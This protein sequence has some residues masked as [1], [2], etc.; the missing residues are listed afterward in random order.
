LRKSSL[1]FLFINLIFIANCWSQTLYLT[2]EGATKDETRIIDSLSYINRFKDIESFNLEKKIFEK[3]LYTL[4]YIENNE[5]SNIKINDSTY[6]TTYALNTL[7]KSINV[8][9]DQELISKNLLASVSDNIHADYFSI[10]FARVEEK[11]N[12]IN[13]QLA[14]QGTPF[15]TL[16]LKNIQKKNSNSLNANLFISKDLKRAINKIVINGYEKFSKSF[17]KR[18]L[19]IR[20][21]E[22]FDLEN[23]KQK[24]QALNELSF[25][26]QVKS[27]EVLFTKDSTTLYM[28]LEKKPSNTFDGFLGFGTN[29]N[30]NKIAFDG[31]LNLNLINN[32][33]YGE[34]LRLL[35]KSDENEQKTFEGTLELPYIF[36]SPM[37]TELQLNIF[38]KDSSFTTIRQ[39]AKLFYQINPKSKVLVGVN[40]TQSNNLLDNMSTLLIDD[41]NTTFYNLGYSYA[42]RERYSALFPV[43]FKF[44]LEVG[45]GKRTFEN[46]DLKQTNMTYD[47]FKIFNLNDKNSL[48]IRSNGA[49]LF[50]DNYF[51]NELYRFGGINSIRGFE[52]NSLFAS[53][54]ALINTE[55][56][57]KL[58]N[59]IYIHSIIDAAYYEND[60]ANLK[61]KLF[62]FGFGFGLLT[63]SGLLKF[64]YA[65]G[66]NENKKFKFSDSKIHISL[67][68]S[69]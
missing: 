24:T 30:T 44:F 27:P 41:Y 49:F 15:K 63:N 17:L 12:Y 5:I 55:Y 65:N 7:Y 46:S 6:L 51:F 38:K 18:Y 14:N 2:I 43:N 40:A 13:R 64:N 53:G 54:F 39:L 67:T 20:L 56:R 60:I 19:K 21:H 61:E 8:Y 32:L 28:Y 66:K 59:S 33:N 62:G 9:Y 1:L 35:Y 3:K 69:F 22:T 52:E 36:S 47:S 37:G 45:S 23:I 50:S 26:S 48:Y 16:Q 25:A 34:S 31:Y 57:Y 4:G 42:A 58:S 29:E 10:P 68:A 11:L